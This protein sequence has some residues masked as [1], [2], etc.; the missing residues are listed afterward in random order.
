M[1]WEYKSVKLRLRGFLGGKLDQD[2]VDM[3]LEESGREG[4][5]LVTILATALYQGRT[6][7]AALVF[8]RPRRNGY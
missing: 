7:D 1:Q 2:E 5:E 4:W 3:L 8:K 6:R